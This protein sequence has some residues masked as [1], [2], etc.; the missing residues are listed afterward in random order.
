MQGIAFFVKRPRR[1]N[2]LF[3]PHKIADEA[4]YEIMRTIRLSQIDYENFTADFTVEREF[5]E[6]NAAL[7]GIDDGVWKCLLI[8][9][10]NAK[11]GILIM[12]ENQCWV[13]YAAYYGNSIPRFR[14]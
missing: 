6:Q 4:P 14:K 11:N 8:Q 5:I 13:G 9:Q 10:E 7:C 3:R 12:P 1:I 2:N